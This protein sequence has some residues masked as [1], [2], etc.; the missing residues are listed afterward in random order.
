MTELKDIRII[1][2]QKEREKYKRIMKARRALELKM[3]FDED[4]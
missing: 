3:N 1:V 4:D 2:S